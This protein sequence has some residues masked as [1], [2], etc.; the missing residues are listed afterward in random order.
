MGAPFH[1]VSVGFRGSKSTSRSRSGRAW[2]HGADRRSRRD[3][4]LRS[5]PSAG[6]LTLRPLRG[7]T[8]GYAR[9]SAHRCFS[10][11]G[12]CRLAGLRA[13]SPLGFAASPLCR[14]LAPRRFAATPPICA[15]QSPA[16]CTPPDRRFCARHS[17]ALGTPP[18]RTVR[19]PPR[20]ATPPDSALATP[21]R[22]APAGPGL[23]TPPRARHSRQPCATPHRPCGCHPATRSPLPPILLVASLVLAA[24]SGSCGTWALSSPVCDKIQPNRFATRSGSRR[25]V[26]K[27][28]RHA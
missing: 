12:L 17:P 26:G 4:S 6:P 22:A 5:L 3:R 27:L 11:R 24:R 21:S 10:D 18:H 1:A 13:R 16:L 7:P 28:R 25:G 8:L 15:R 23:I 20:L 2:V 19:F 14:T 9:A